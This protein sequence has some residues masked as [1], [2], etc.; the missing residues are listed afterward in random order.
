MTERFDPRFFLAGVWALLVL[1]CGSSGSVDSGA[2]TDAAAGMQSTSGAVFQAPTF[3]IETRSDV[4]YGQGLT[5]SY[6]NAPD[7]VARD[8]LLDVYLPINDETDRPAIMFIHGGGF[9]SGDKATAA[10]VEFARYFAERG[11]VSLSI[12]YRLL[13][14]YGT[15]PASFNDAIDTSP[16][17]INTDR[18]QIKAMYPAVRDAKAALRWLAANAD[19]YG[20]D[21]NRI[22]VIGGSAGSFI[23]IAIGASDIDDYAAELNA[24]EDPTITSINLDEPV[25]AAAVVNHWGG[26][27]A[28]TLLDLVDGRSRWGPEDA[29]LSIVHGT[30]DATVAYEQALELVDVYQTTGAA[31]ELVTL[32][33]AGHAAWNATVDGQSLTALGFSF[34]TRMLEL[35]VR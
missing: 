4:V 6:W 32:D 11:F 3:G 14:D 20:V 2:S 8:L 17:L 12:G 25:I 10:P 18:D 24:D 29:P 7:P 21:P 28:V 19:E 15:L 16:L 9:V 22:S 13:G 26:P 33:G 34:I 23:A 35:D 1:G 5:H 31:Y 30:A 27:A